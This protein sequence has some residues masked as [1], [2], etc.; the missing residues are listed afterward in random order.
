MTGFPVLYLQTLKL[1]TSINL[2]ICMQEN[3]LQVLEKTIITYQC[4]VVWSWN[5]AYFVCHEFVH[6]STYSLRWCILLCLIRKADLMRKN[7]LQIPSSPQHKETTVTQKL[8]HL[9]TIFC[10]H[11]EQAN[12]MIS[13]DNWA[14]R[15]FA[16]YRARKYIRNFLQFLRF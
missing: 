10:T 11:N 4:N 2:F 5:M 12:T 1:G 3:I 13:R 16:D 7:H 14:E 9:L 8:I 15:S 6:L